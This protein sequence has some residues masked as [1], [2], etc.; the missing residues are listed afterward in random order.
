MSINQGDNGG[1]N[2][3]NGQSNFTSYPPAER[4][5]RLHKALVNDEV[6]SDLISH[7]FNAFVEEYSNPERMQKLHAAL[8][9]DVV[10]GEFVPS[11]YEDAIEWMGFTTKPESMGKSLPTTQNR[12]GRGGVD[13]GVGSQSGLQSSSPGRTIDDFGVTGVGGSEPEF[14]YEVD[15]QAAEEQSES[16][17]QQRINQGVN[18]INILVNAA[19]REGR[20]LIEKGLSEGLSQREYQR[21]Y[22]VLEGTQFRDYIS[23][24]NPMTDFVSPNAFRQIFVD[25][26]TAGG[27]GADYSTVTK[28]GDFDKLSE[29]AN[30]EAV[31]QWL[32]GFD[33]RMQ[34]KVGDRAYR[35]A[36][37]QARATYGEKAESVINNTER[38]IARQS[39]SEEERAAADLVRELNDLVGSGRDLNNEELARAAELD[40]KIKTAEVELGKMGTLYDPITG[41]FIPQM[42]APEFAAEVSQRE[43]ELSEV[44]D[45]DL[46][47]DMRRKA[48]FAFAEYR[49]KAGDKD[50][51]YEW[52]PGQD[53]DVDRMRAAW[54]EF[55]ALNRV[56]E[57]NIDPA[58][59][60]REGENLGALRTG[61]MGS[62]NLESNRSVVEGVIDAFRRSGLTPTK[63]QEERL[64]KSF[65]E[66]IGESV[67]ASFNIAIKMAAE[68]ALTRGMR[69][70]LGLNSY[71]NAFRR[72]LSAT[73]LGAKA[74][75]AVNVASKIIGGALDV[76]QSGLI[77]EGAGQNFA[78]GAG[79]EIAQK[80]V[81]LLT[82]GKAGR[83]IKL[84]S[85]TVGETFAE[86]VGEFADVLNEFGIDNLDEAFRETFGRNPESAM[87]K[88]LITLATIAPFA[89]LSA[90]GREFVDSVE[91]YAE[92]QPDSEVRSEVLGVIDFLKEEAEKKKGGAAAPDGGATVAAD[93]EAAVVE[94]TP[95]GVTEDAVMGT[96]P[97]SA[98]SP[99]T[100]SSAVDGSAQVERNGV[101][102][103]LTLDGQTIVFEHSD[104]KTIEDVGNVDEIS[105]S[106]I[107]DFGFNEVQRIDLEVNPETMSVV[108]DGVE[109]VNNYSKPDAAINTDANGDVVSVTL[110]TKD[111]KKRTFRGERAQEIAYQYKLI[112]FEKNATE[113]QIQSALERVRQIAETTSGNVED[114][115]K[116]QADG[117]QGV[118]QVNVGETINPA[119]ADLESTAAALEGNGQAIADVQAVTGMALPDA[120]AISESY[121][122]AKA[123]PEAE[124]TAQE[125]GLI[126]AVEN[127]LTSKTETDATKEQGA[128]EVLV[129]DRPEASEAVRGQDTEGGEVTGEGKAATKEGEAEIQEE[130]EPVQ[131]NRVS[132]IVEDLRSDPS[133]TEV[134]V[135]GNDIV[136]SKKDK[137]GRVRYYE[138]IGG[139]RSNQ[140]SKTD[141]IFKREIA[142]D[143]ATSIN[144]A[145]IPLE[146]EPAFLEGENQASLNALDSAP[147]VKSDGSLPESTLE[148][149]EQDKSESESLTEEEID[150]IFEEG[151]I[152]LTAVTT[153]S[154]EQKKSAKKQA[155]ERY[156]ASKKRLKES[157]RDFSS[158]AQSA[159]ITPT[160][161]SQK[162]QFDAMLVVFKD[163]AVL[164]KDWALKKAISGADLS[165]LTYFDFKRD[166]RDVFSDSAARVK[167]GSRFFDKGE[168]SYASLAFDQ[169]MAMALDP[170]HQI[171]TPREKTGSDI[172]DEL[173]N[174]SEREAKTGFNFAS[175]SAKMLGSIASAFDYNASLK[176]SII[177]LSNRIKKAGIQSFSVRE[178]FERLQFAVQP[179]SKIQLKYEQFTKAVY[180]GL[181]KENKVL[182]DSIILLRSVISLEIA[183]NE[184]RAKIAEFENDLVANHGF[185]AKTLEKDLNDYVAG[186]SAPK[187]FE[188]MVKDEFVNNYGA[189]PN[190]LDKNLND[191]ANGRPVPREFKDKVYD[192]LEANGTSPSDFRLSLRSVDVGKKIDAYLTATNQTES[193]F[194]SKIRSIEGKREANKG[195]GGEYQHPKGLRLDSAKDA[196]AVVERV[197]GKDVYDDLQMR[198]DAYFEYSR[199]LLLDRLNAG[200]ISQYL[201]DEIVNREYVPRIWED[202]ELIE[203]FSNNPAYG[204][205][206]F[207]VDSNKGGYIGIKRLKGGSS[208]T[209]EAVLDSRLLMK[210]N[211]AMAVQAIEN[212][213]LMQFVINELVPSSEAY[214]DY[215]IKEAIK[216]N[217]GK[218]ISASQERKIRRDSQIVYELKRIGTGK[219]GKPKFEPPMDGFAEFVFSD[220]NTTRAFAALESPGGGNFLSNMR[221]GKKGF[222]GKMKT[223]LNITRMVM[224]VPII[225]MTAVGINAAFAVAQL[226]SMDIMHQM[227]VAPGTKVVPYSYAKRVLYGTGMISGKAVQRAL[228]KT[229]VLFSKLFSKQK[230]TPQLTYFERELEDAIAHG[231]DFS[232]GILG[233]KRYSFED[234]KKFGE[235][236]KRF[237]SVLEEGIRDTELANRLVSYKILVK[238][239][240]K[241]KEREVKRDLTDEEISAIKRSAAYDISNVLNYH[242]RGA[243]SEAVDAIIPFFSAA[244]NAMKAHARFLPGK[245]GRAGGGEPMSA[246]QKA[247]YYANVGQF[248]GGSILLSLWMFA[249]D[250]EDERNGVIPAGANGHKD[251]LIIPL[252]VTEDDAGRRARAFVSLPVD[253]MLGGFNLIGKRIAQELY[254]GSEDTWTE[255]NRPQYPVTISDI[256]NKF[257][258]ETIP[259]VGSVPPTISAISALAFNFD[260]YRMKTIYRSEGGTPDPEN[261]ADE[262]TRAIFRVLAR[263]VNLPSKQ[264]ETAF[265]KVVSLNNPLTNGLTTA[266]AQLMPEDMRGEGETWENAARAG[267]GRLYGVSS[268]KRIEEG[269][270]EVTIA[271]GNIGSDRASDQ[272]GMV[273]RELE[274]VPSSKRAAN[275]RLFISAVSGKASMLKRENRGYESSRQVSRLKSANEVDYER[276]RAVIAAYKRGQ[277]DVVN[278]LMSLPDGYFSQSSPFYLSLVGGNNENREIVGRIIMARE[279]EKGVERMSTIPVAQGFLDRLKSMGITGA[280]AFDL[281]EALAKLSIES[282]KRNA[283]KQ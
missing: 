36:T 175:F 185:D 103:T 83:L 23:E 278:D 95:A 249:K 124:R 157:W 143:N 46:L 216:K 136:Y 140:L 85:G 134:H 110:E 217:G 263:Y 64:Q 211:T 9:Q 29:Q 71:T 172:L 204:G 15:R 104:G 98:K 186:R 119:L 11:R 76:G 118:E 168:D 80:V 44:K 129:G 55:S 73:R 174:Q 164:A 84:L 37:E 162:A 271:I 184:R 57:L 20:S 199:S 173:I 66:Q 257:L 111:G 219:D 22:D 51:L 268:R 264:L 255:G 150:S 102:G 228:N 165:K 86:Y 200:Q 261:M 169:G 232:G 63:E 5:S 53:A 160:P 188:K 128:A 224:G 78:T 1:G 146:G 117:T 26:I 241:Q 99:V 96:A 3:S 222:T 45:L 74:P 196:L 123:K 253:K 231:L 198:A 39:I 227:M 161:Q 106:S 105:E 34:D 190:T 276:G 33:S 49:K 234:K 17:R 237:I 101:T 189:D 155:E 151:G 192:Y 24:V 183:I 131:D 233:Q 145:G 14:N 207:G 274:K 139:G 147:V 19:G 244:V 159:N 141:F 208:K 108:I 251:A 116:G 171:Q 252:W 282:D 201:Y 138:K 239:K 258:Y 283:K 223:T 82:K 127:L 158:K 247:D 230:P 210:I 256:S 273:F 205:F 52:I 272:V 109:Y 187:G 243:V 62:P 259:G 280:D 265:G 100:V 58:T 60:S 30:S 209:E 90:I 47:K 8:S 27:S 65:G 81:D 262:R 107:S 275:A 221:M 70:V 248:I 7:N 202:S 218:P 120:Q 18:Q 112:D 40:R 179:G 250:E 193:D 242:N 10:F 191:Y 135:S 122:A 59:I 213:R 153:M 167:V 132:K 203:E 115:G 154:P 212:H 133:V 113:E 126:E 206:D 121:H 48:Y 72:V 32:S 87:D 281:A 246:R 38:L 148:V 41:K 181:T 42:R 16:L 13:S 130:V 226:V 28:R 91:R 194:K 4:V 75:K 125:I 178:F 54:K 35:A 177:D 61:F 56:I 43:E 31:N 25:G 94:E 79:E 180:N 245:M 225:K 260:L 236:F 114:T 170:N 197:F 240:M 156:E 176:N 238:S 6:F 254:Y 235:S 279:R 137:N 149:M 144:E 92:S 2:P 229:R 163:L 266:F 277:S 195:I 93:T 215:Q 89:G 270:T 220:G 214:V 267:F 50:F 12:Q 182:L 69:G 142:M 97:E 21:L 152:K 68:M 88:L 166:N 67:G 269:E 77:F